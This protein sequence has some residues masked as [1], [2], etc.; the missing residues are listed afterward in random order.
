MTIQTF[1]KEQLEQG[2]TLG[3][4]SKVLEVSPAALSYQ[5]N[6]KSKSVSLQLAQKI[7]HLYNVQLDGFDLIEFE[8]PER[9]KC[10]HCYDISLKYNHVSGM[11]G[12]HE[13]ERC[14]KEFKW[15]VEDI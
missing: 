8:D 11:T 9:F 4:L 10:P 2:K 6:G 1:L 7:Y 5:L 14:G 12:V 15:S 13:C 3:R